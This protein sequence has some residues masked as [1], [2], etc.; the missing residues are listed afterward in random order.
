MHFDTLR[1]T[2]YVHSVKYVTVE[3]YIIASRLQRDV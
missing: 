1:P 3:F 2:H